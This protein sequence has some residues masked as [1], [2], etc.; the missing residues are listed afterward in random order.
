MKFSEKETLDV[1]LEN[2]RR[3]PDSYEWNLKA[4]LLLSGIRKSLLHGEPYL[5]KALSHGIKD[6]FTR[7]ALDRLGLIYS[8]KGLYDKVVDIY[9]I[10]CE[11]VPETPDF[12]FRLGDALFRTGRVEEALAVY[13]DAVNKLYKT[14]ELFSRR[15]GEPVTHLLNPHLVICRYF[16]EMAE[17]GRASCRERV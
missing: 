17:I 3:E 2:V 7:E 11:V 13:S 1:L 9:R 6:E 5:V 10:A 14:A 16:G 4:G 15:R 8:A 12:R